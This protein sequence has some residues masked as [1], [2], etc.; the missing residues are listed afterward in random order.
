LLRKACLGALVELEPHVVGHS[1]RPD[2]LL[3]RNV[4]IG[5]PSC[6]SQL[7]S[8]HSDQITD[9]TNLD[10]E[11]VKLYHYRN[12]N[13]PVTPFAVEATGRF[14]PSALN[15]IKSVTQQMGKSRAIYLQQIQYAIAY[16]QWSEMFTK[17]IRS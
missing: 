14:G 5:N 12:W 4:V 13:I 7:N 3:Y 8:H 17:T 16:I 1:E 15:F 11:R 10:K 6:P 9:A 2:I